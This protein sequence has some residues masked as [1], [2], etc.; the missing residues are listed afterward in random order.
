[1]KFNYPVVIEG[2]DISLKLDV[3]TIP[4]TAT[5]NGLRADDMTMDFTYTIQP[6]HNTTRLN[7]LQQSGES[8]LVVLGGTFVTRKVTNVGLLANMHTG[9]AANS[10]VSLGQSQYIT[11]YG[12]EA[13]VSE[14]DVVGVNPASPANNELYPDNTVDILVRWNVAVVTTCSPILVMKTGDLTNTRNAVFISGNK[15]KDFIFRYTIEVGDSSDH[16]YIR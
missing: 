12:E 9:L 10:S 14:I 5:F 15:T 8:A 11:I 2:T 6:D 1:M 3:G 16:I 13:K 7:V 4:G